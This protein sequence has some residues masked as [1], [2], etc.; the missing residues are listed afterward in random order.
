M[1]NFLD[2]SNLSERIY[3]YLRNQIVQNQMPP[4]T[5]INY[6]QL[7]SDL[8]V[9]RMPLREAVNQLS[10]DGLIEVKPRSGTFVNTPKRQDIED[11]YD[12][13][14]ALEELS[15]ELAIPEIPLSI[16]EK[17]EDETS[18][19]EEQLNKRIVE[20]FFDADRNLH[21]T[22]IDYSNNIR[23]Q[24]IWKSIE[25]QVQWVGVIITTN[26]DRPFAANDMHKEILRAI[27]K[28]ETDT[29]KQLMRDHINQIKAFTISDHGQ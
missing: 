29:A 16:I 23:L 7:A 8:N 13:R 5:R 9:S 10:Q 25:T 21:R 24:Q 20:P 12:L 11:L 22:L 3:Y 18:Y 17:L 6:E 2:K 27:K 1:E 14:R 19:S 26:L 4:G 28:R 15:V